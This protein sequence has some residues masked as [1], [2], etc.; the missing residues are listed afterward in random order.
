MTFFASLPPSCD[1][2]STLCEWYGSRVGQR[3]FEEERDQLGDILQNLFGYHLV[4]VGCPLPEDLLSGSRIS[5][6]L[7]IDPRFPQASGTR[8]IYGLPAALPLQ[9][10]SVD[11]VVLP[12]TLEFVAAPHETLREMERVL[13]PE[14]HVVILGFNPYSLWGLWRVVNRRRASAPWSGRFFGLTRVKDWLALLGFDIVL[15]RHYF[16]RPPL[17]G[18]RIMRRLRFMDSLGARAWP[19]LSGLYVIVG[20]KRVSAMTPIR[21]RWRPRRSLI[22]KLAPASA[23]NSP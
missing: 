2:P 11:V 15:T 3:L 6:R 9:A 17:R 7:V 13:I 1:T 8:S 22:G 16:F 23:R 14:G 4:Q 20:R 21:P 19:R 18:E 12:H 5:H 10:D